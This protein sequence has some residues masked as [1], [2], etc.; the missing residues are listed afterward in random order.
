MMRACFSIFLAAL[1]ARYV[2]GKAIDASHVREASKMEITQPPVPRRTYSPEVF[3]RQD[4]D[5]DTSFNS[6]VGYKYFLKTCGTYSFDSVT[7]TWNINS[8]CLVDYSG[9]FWGACANGISQATD[10]G[11]PQVCTDSFGCKLGC[12]RTTVPNAST[13]TWYDVVS[14]R[15]KDQAKP[16]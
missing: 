5:S 2:H 1:L 9:L 11:W 3:R 12:G 15:I 13:L 6:F 14:N 7:Q 10:C 8:Q 4:G 16:Y